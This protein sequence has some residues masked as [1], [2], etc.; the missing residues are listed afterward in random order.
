MR[1]YFD[2]MDR[3]GSGESGDRMAKCKDCGTTVKVSKNNTSNLMSHLRTRLPK[4]HEVA[5]QK[6]DEKKHKEA[7]QAKKKSV[8]TQ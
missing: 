7:S 6:S 2:N 5:R 1:L 8:N 3:V 4:I